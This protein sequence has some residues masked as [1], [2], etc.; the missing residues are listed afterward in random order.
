M[1][2]LDPSR[3]SRAE[4]QHAE[5]IDPRMFQPALPLPHGYGPQSI[6]WASSATKCDAVE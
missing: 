2:E 5:L 4:A 3:D 1:T 6:V